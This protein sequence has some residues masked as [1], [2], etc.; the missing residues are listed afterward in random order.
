LHVAIDIGT[1][2]RRIFGCFTDGLGVALDDEGRQV[3]GAGSMPICRDLGTY[4]GLAIFG[5]DLD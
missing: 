4:L 1:G 5:E 3:A 2:V